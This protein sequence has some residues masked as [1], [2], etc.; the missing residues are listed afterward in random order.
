MATEVLQA[1]CA[2]LQALQNTSDIILNMDHPS[3]TMKIIFLFV[4]MKKEEHTFLCLKRLSSTGMPERRN[5][6]TYNLP[7]CGGSQT[8][9]STPSITMAVTHLQSS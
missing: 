8:T 3:Q 5:A 2:L 6:S 7:N 1:P 9:I 4:C